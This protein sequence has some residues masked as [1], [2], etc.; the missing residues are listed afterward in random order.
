LIKTLGLKFIDNN[1][2]LL[3]VIKIHRNIICENVNKYNV[4]IIVDTIVET[5]WSLMNNFHKRE[6]LNMCDEFLIRLYFSYKNSILGVWVI[7]S[8]KNLRF[9]VKRL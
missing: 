7:L 1:L 9:Y 4:K 2:L 8:Q 6:Y 5:L 3:V